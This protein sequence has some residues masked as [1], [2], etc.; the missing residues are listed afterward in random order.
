M[1]VPLARILVYSK[2]LSEVVAGRL[3]VFGNVMRLSR[4][5][6]PAEAQLVKVQFAHVQAWR[7]QT[8]ADLFDAV[9]SWLA[10]QT[11]A[12]HLQLH[13]WSLTPV[14][15]LMLAT[16]PDERALSSVVQ[17]IGRRLAANV[18]VGGVFA[19]RYKSALVAPELALLTQIWIELAAL[20][21]GCT[22]KAA[23]WAWSSAAAHAGSNAS[24]RQWVMPLTDHPAY[25]SCGNTPFD[26]QA[27]Y[28]NKLVAGLDA[29]SQQ[30]IES[31]IAGQWALG[32]ESYIAKISKLASRR[33]TPGKRGR[34]VRTITAGV[35][36]IRP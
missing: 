15:L 6:A 23:D 8:P 33:V 21:E 31:A 26:R 5:Y 9:A 30:R 14:S 20:R 13:A 16:P 12:R 3:D 29:M 19:G 32:P 35:G 36:K 34:P 18:R 28:Q 7:D 1:E 17:A 4:L 11:K 10:E 2:T 22:S 24:T 25:W 27:A